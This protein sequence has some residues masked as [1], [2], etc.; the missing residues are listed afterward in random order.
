MTWARFRFGVIAPLLTSPPARGLL[1]A[2]LDAVC[3]KTYQ[4]PL[5]GEPL[6]LGRSTVERW[7]YLAKSRPNAPLEA[8]ARSPHPRAGERKSLSQGLVAVLEQQYRDHPT[9][10]RQVHHK[11]LVTVAASDDAL[12][13]APSYATLCRFMNE[14]G[15]VRRRRRKKGAREQE[16]GFIPRERRSYE[17]E[18]VMSLVHADFHECSRQV[19]FRDGTRKKPWLFG[20]LDDRSRLCL[21]LQWYAVESTETFVHGIS[22]AILKRGLFRSFLS[23]NG[24][25]FTSAESTQG[26]ERLGVI[27]HTTLAY[28]PEQNGKQENFWTR[29]EGQLMPMLEGEKGLTLELLNRATQAWVERDYHRAMHR[30][31]RQT[32]LEAFL[33]G[34]SVARHSPSAGELRRK[35]REEIT[36]KQRRSDGTVTVRGVRF[37]VPSAYR[38]MRDVAVRVARWDLSSIGMVDPHT[39]AEIT[40]LYPI[41]KTAN[42]DRKRRAL[43]TPPTATEPRE[44]GVAPYLEGLIEEQERETRAPAYVPH[45]STSLDDD[46]ELP[47]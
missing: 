26:F 8:L 3:Q 10:T 2:E 14:K 7:Y 34:E 21:H 28:S 25:S 5:S 45:D 40:E 6:R 9:W 29:I 35:F 41:D 20:C 46:E 19:L 32:P 30:E 42:A 37:E 1:R 33:S 4:D 13:E 23:D 18:H 12:G 24:G 36:R 15:W 38:H 22:Q 27:Q 16:P 31:L 47:F 39:G 44:T 43:D 17:V 11:N